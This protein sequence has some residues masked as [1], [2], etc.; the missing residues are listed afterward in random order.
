M[1]SPVV[2]RRILH[3]DTHSP[4]ATLAIVLA[5]A[6]IVL[7]A[8]SITEIILD[9]VG[10]PP[11]LTSMPALASAVAGV[12]TLPAGLVVPI[13]VVLAVI[14]AI[15]RAFFRSEHRFFAP[16][17][18]AQDHFGFGSKGGRAFRGLEHAEASAGA[19]P[20]EDGSPTRL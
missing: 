13:G 6:V 11:L 19:C 3:R 17:H 16:R 14:G 1:T 20:H 9:L 7:C 2:Y 4:R 18:Y 15:F 10:Q 5:I 12:A 8:W